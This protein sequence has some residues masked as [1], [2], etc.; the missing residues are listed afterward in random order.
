MSRGALSALPHTGGH[1]GT[2]GLREAAGAQVGDPMAHGPPC[3][4]DSPHETQDRLGTW[5]ES[6]WSRCPFPDLSFKGKAS[7]CLQ[8]QHSSVGK[9]ATKMLSSQMEKCKSWQLNGRAQVTEPGRFGAQAQD[10]KNLGPCGVQTQ[11]CLSTRRRGQ[12][13]EAVA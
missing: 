13:P 1:G 7:Y 3:N 12:V 2:L 4:C 10:D 6:P 9:R 5:L 11:L 8:T